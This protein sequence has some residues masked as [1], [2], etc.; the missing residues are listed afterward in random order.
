MEIRLC[1]FDEKQTSRLATLVFTALLVRYFTVPTLHND[2]CINVVASTGLG[3]GKLLDIVRQTYC[4]V[5]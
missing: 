5:S 3:C 2:C 4:C 1:D